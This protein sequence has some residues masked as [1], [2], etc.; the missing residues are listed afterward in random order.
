MWEFKKFRNQEFVP[1][2]KFLVEMY[3]PDSYLE[4]GI[5]KGYT[6]AQ[7]SPLVK[8]AVGVDPNPLYMS[9]DI[10]LGTSEQYAKSIDSD[11]IFD[12]ILIDGLHEKSAV[13]NDVD[14]FLP[15]LRDETGLMLLHDTYPSTPS[16]EGIGYCHDAWKAARDIFKLEK[17]KDVEIVTLPGPY[18]GMS[19]LRKAKKHLH[20][21]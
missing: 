8:E 12:L 6:F 1:L 16:L 21:L 10:F 13:L 3:S 18:A 7:I 5:Q 15:H 2:L 11:K 20:W 14:M 19:I 17:Y 9:G 4:I